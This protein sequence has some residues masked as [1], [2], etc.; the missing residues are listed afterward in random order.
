MRIICPHCGARDLREYEYLGSA[1][2]LSRPKGAADFYDYVYVRENPSG[3]NAE[4]WQH[5][6]G[7]RAWLHVRRNVTTH[8]IL[9]VKLASDIAGGKP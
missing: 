2:L 6:M 7:C 8:E 5:T 1:K 4:L 9:D 3:E